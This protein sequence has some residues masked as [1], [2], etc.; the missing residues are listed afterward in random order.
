MTTAQASVLAAIVQADAQSPITVAGLAYATGLHPRTVEKATAALIAE[1]KV[2]RVFDPV[3]GG[4]FLIP[5][6]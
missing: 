1:K 3:T 6:K 2:G 4:R 5:I